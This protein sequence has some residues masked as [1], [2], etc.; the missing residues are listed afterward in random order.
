MSLQE[1][2][3]KFPD[4]TFR[5]GPDGTIQRHYPLNKKKEWK[6]VCVHNRT[7]SACKECGGSSFCEHGSMKYRC[8]KCATGTAICEHGRIKYHCT[9]CEGSCICI[10][11]KQRRTCKI[12]DG[13]AY[14]PHNKQHSLCK[15]C[16][17]AGLCEHNQMRLFCKECKGSQIC[18]HN[19]TK[20]R[21]KQCAGNGICE[22]GKR[23]TRCN[24]CGGSELCQICN[25]NMAHEDNLCVTCH[26][27]YIPPKTGASK[28][29]CKFFDQLEQ[30]VG[31][32]THIHYN[33]ISGQCDGKEFRLPE[34]S[35]KPV[36]GH[37]PGTK[38]VFEFLGDKFHGHPKQKETNHLGESNQENFQETEASFQK[39]ASFGYEIW[40]IWECD[41][42]HID[43]TKTLFS[44]CRKFLGKLES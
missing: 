15:D 4:H 23:K 11:K 21:C 19:T 32:I 28:I 1:F 27:D 8:V 20:H 43:K 26:P 31:E 16:G 38:V 36:D 30:E 14:C 39:M 29:A 41:F 5:L 18:E 2:Q 6:Y 35:S 22:H 44:Q 7:P 42:L 33:V 9:D 13:S 12:C 3:Q 10:H 25:T 40:Y 37:I 24:L 17:G 34:W